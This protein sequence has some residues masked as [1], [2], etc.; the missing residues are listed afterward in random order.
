M[1]DKQVYIS[2]RTL[3]QNEMTGEGKYTRL[4]EFLASRTE[5]EVAVSF[6]EL[7]QALGFSLPGSARMHPAWWANQTPPS[8]QSRVW[9][10]AGWRAYPNLMAGIV[11]FKRD[12]G[13]SPALGRKQTLPDAFVQSPEHQLQ[14]DEAKERLRAFLES[15]GWRTTIALG[16]VPG[17]D[18]EAFREGQRW[19]IEVKGCGSLSAMRVNYFLGALGELLQRMSDPEAKYSV[20]FPD[21]AQFRRLWERLGTVAKERTGITCLFVRSNGEITEVS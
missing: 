18:I 5:R 6:V 4:G 8:P 2:N 21:L 7:E 14:E 13:R 19:I 17:I 12:A 11:T 9:T 1:G 16:K 10:S 3:A 15:A 20:A